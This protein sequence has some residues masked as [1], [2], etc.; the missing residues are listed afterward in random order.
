MFD[1]LFEL[2]KTLWNDIVPY[3]IIAEFESACIL[4]WG[5]FH[6]VTNAG[7]YWKLPFGDYVY[8]YHVR[9][10][11]THLTPQTLTTNDKKS[12]VVKAIVRYHI[13]DV[14]AY[15]LSVLNAHDA[16]C[17]TTQ[18]II[19]NLVK[20]YKWLEILEGVEDEITSRVAEAVKDWGITIEKVTLCD[21]GEIRTIR[22]I[23][24]PQDVNSTA[25][26]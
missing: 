11:T 26:Y 23:N 25:L 4:R 19:C 22:I 3:Y 13:Q 9:T 15:T 6:R 12:V 5:K 17:D 10:Q 21:L 18:G 7:I 24:N 2:L 14:K 20:E 1:K 16:I 8:A